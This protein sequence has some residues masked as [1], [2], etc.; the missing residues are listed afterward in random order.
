MG[1]SQEEKERRGGGECGDEQRCRDTL[2]M[3]LGYWGWL[4]GGTFYLLA[5]EFRVNYSVKCMDA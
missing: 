4:S 2:R 1:E 5:L 3:L